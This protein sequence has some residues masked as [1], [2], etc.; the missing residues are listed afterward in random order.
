MSISAMNLCALNNGTGKAG[1]SE[2]DG[3]K[4]ALVVFVALVVVGSIAIRHLMFPQRFSDSAI[5]IPGLIVAFL[6][7]ATSITMLLFYAE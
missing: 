4:I 2:L 6:I 5:S 1:K 3:Q 7:V